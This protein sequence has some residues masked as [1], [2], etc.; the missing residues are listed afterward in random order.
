MSVPK[1]KRGVANSSYVFHART[2]LDMTRTIMRKWPKGRLR[3]ETEH[4]MRIAYDAYEAAASAAAVYA[5]LPNEHAFK[6]AELTRAYGKVHALGGL[7]DGW[8]KDCPTVKEMPYIPENIT[9]EQ[10]FAKY[11]VQDRSEV[12]PVYRKAVSMKTLK[13]YGGAVSRT[14]SALSGAIKHQR[15]ALKGSLEK[16]PSFVLALPC[17]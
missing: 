15:S 1:S 3:L 5:V 7:C 8:L 2:L 6:L 11:G 16:N 9:H 13:N 12:G 17:R 4:V 10:L 14:C